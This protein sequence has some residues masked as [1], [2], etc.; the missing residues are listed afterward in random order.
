MS[1]DWNSPVIQRLIE[2]KADLLNRPQH[3][4]K[5]AIVR[6]LKGEDEPDVESFL[7]TL[8]SRVNAAIDAFTETQNKL[9]NG[10]SI[11][12]ITPEEIKKQ[13]MEKHHGG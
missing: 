8:H 13:L 11:G 4:R 12:I 2:A 1:V 9:F 7:A 5:S 3:I 10:P 6:F